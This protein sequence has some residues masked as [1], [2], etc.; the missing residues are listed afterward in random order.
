MKATKHMDFFGL[1]SDKKTKI[2]QKQALLKTI[3]S[4]QFKALQEIFCN[5]V[6]GNL[7]YEGRK[8]LK[9]NSKR[10]KLMNRLIKSKNPLIIRHKQFGFVLPTLQIAW[11]IIL[12]HLDTLMNAEINKDKDKQE[13]QLQQQNNSNQ[14]QSQSKPSNS[15]NNNN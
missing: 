15:N 8:K 6:N 7:E 1:L 11:S 3:D 2:K 14:E 4:Q 5:I 13:L 12:N 10:L 9:R